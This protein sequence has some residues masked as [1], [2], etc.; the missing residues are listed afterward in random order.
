[1]TSSGVERKATCRALFSKILYLT[2]HQ[3]LLDQESEARQDLSLQEVNTEI[4]FETELAVTQIFGATEEDESKLR[5]VSLEEV[6]LD[7]LDK[8]VLLFLSLP[9]TWLCALG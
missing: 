9:V 6:D 1:M 8:M 2:E 7:K 4:M 5:I 3:P